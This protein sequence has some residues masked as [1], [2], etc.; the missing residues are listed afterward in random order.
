VESIFLA[1]EE[2]VNESQRMQGAGSTP[3]S[4]DAAGAL[5]EI[6]RRQGQVIEAVLVPVWYWWVVAIAMVAIGAAA[7][8]KR[9][10][11]LAVV[12]PIAVLV[13]A[14]LT[15]A[16]IVGAYRRVQ[17]HSATMLGGRGAIAIIGLDWLVVGVS[18]GTAFG[19]R[20]AGSRFAGTIGTVVGAVVLVIAGP[21]VMRYLRRLMLSQ[22][23]G[24]A[25]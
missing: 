1:E 3:A 25:G 23:S 21:A 12:I 24:S 2:N 5:A 18:L 6:Q 11:V 13:I 14:G 20:A 9:P 22:R 8:T 16:M 19:L 7:D 10:A 4:A 15:A 17:V